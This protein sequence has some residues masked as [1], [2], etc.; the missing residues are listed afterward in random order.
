METMNPFDAALQQLADAA[1]FVDVSDDVLA[2][3]R[4][5]QREIQ[6][7]IPMRMDDGSLRVFTGYRVQHNNARGPHKGGIRFHP[8]TN[9]DEVRALAFWMTFKC[10]AVGIPLGGGKGGVTVNPKELSESEL[11]RLSRGWAR[12]F[13]PFIGPDIDVPAPDVYTTPQIMAWIADEYSSVVGTPTPAVITGKPVEAGGSAGRGTATAQGGMYVTRALLEKMQVEAPRVVVQGFGNA[14]ATYARLAAEAGWKV[15]GVSDSRGA[16]VN[17]DGLDIAAVAAHKAETGSVAGFAGT[18]AV[19]DILAV[20]CDILVPAALEGV[21]TETT[22]P[23]ISAQAVLELANGPTTPEAD[24]QLHARGIHVVPDIVANA[25]GVTV[26]YFEWEQNL[27]G[28]TWTEEEV[29]TKLQPIMEA[30]FADAWGAANEHNVALR[31]GA[32]ISA[33]K[34]LDDAVSSTLPQ[35]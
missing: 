22:A 1:K 6:V 35:A 21:I 9:L 31:T 28:E 15:I 34:R 32:Y 7:S 23:N 24:A 8:D 29:F 25:G 27:S 10:A 2:V 4:Q 16:I 11:E 19:D 14:G 26:S 18:E 17:P 12:A 33:L 20:E 5:P 13:A 3:L 30:A